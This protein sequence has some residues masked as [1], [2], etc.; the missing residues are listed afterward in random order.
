MNTRSYPELKFLT[1]LRNRVF[2]IFVL[3][4]LNLSCQLMS[5]KEKEKE[6]NIQKIIDTNIE[7]AQ[8]RMDEGNPEQALQTLRPILLKFPDNA[9]LLNMIGLTYLAMSRPTQAKLYFKKA[10]KKDKKPA[11]ALNLSSALII[12]RK[13]VV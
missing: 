10:Y 11:Y 8:K 4:G 3:A 7:Y 6:A 2:F 9:P 5:P 1:W 13:S 12:D